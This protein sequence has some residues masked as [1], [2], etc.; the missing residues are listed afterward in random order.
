MRMR[1]KK[2][3]IPRLEKVSHL[4]CSNPEEMKG[5]WG[6]GKPVHLEIGCG[7]G[8]FIYQLAEG[9]PHIQYVALEVVKEAAVMALE[10]VD[11]RDLK[12]VLFIIEDAKN[13]INFFNKGEVDRIYL[14]F[15]DPWP[16]KSKSKR[17][18][19]HPD[20]L[21][22]YKE[23]LK[24]DGEI[25]QK[26]DN[27]DFFEFSLESYKEMGCILSDITYDLHSTNFEDNIMTEYE[28][29]FTKEGKPICRVVAK[30]N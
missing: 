10:K 28:K 13:I 20:F 24:E 3:L 14:N 22:I 25:H 30:F 21:K 4:I 19:T 15:S 6:K 18:L 23:V 9:N 11:S 17:R 5:K 1:T 26:T 16:K 29:K 8:D 2:N 12:N 7:K 27:V